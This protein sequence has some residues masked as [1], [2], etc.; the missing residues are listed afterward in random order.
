MD[1][2]TGDKNADSH[3]CWGAYSMIDR[4]RATPCNDRN[5][6]NSLNT[7]TLVLHN[8]IINL[9]ILRTIQSFSSFIHKR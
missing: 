5:H 4:L 6:Y 9:H 8:T 2:K 3:A 1:V 7:S